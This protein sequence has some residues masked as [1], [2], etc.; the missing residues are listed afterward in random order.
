M[1]KVINLAGFGPHVA[2]RDDLEGLGVHVSQ[3]CSVVENL[4]GRIDVR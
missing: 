4:V 2:E 1:R 3:Q